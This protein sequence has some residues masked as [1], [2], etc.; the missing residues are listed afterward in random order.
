MT[1]SSV[2]EDTGPLEL[3]FLADGNGRLYT[4]P[5]RNSSFIHS[6][7]KGHLDHFQFLVT[8]NKTSISFHVQ[9]FM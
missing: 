8:M 3:F 5:K 9:V 7:V 4:N 1:L 6:P 2:S